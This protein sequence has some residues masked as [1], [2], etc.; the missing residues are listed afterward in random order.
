MM[1][2]EYRFEYPSV[3]ESEDRMLDDLAEIMFR[4]EV[5]DDTA[6]HVAL[7]VSEAFTNALVH[8]NCWEPGKL[9]RLRI[10]LNDAE[11]RA[12]ITDEGRDGLKRIARRRPPSVDSEGGRG[13]DL[14]SHYATD[15]SFRENADGGLTVSLRFVRD[16][17]KKD[18]VS[19]IEHRE[20]A[21]DISMREVGPVAVVN[22]SG[23]LD[24][25]S[26]TM[27]KEE[28]KK[29]FDRNITNIHLNMS[30]VDFINSSGLGALVS[31]MK[32]VRLLKGR[33]TLSNLASYVKEIFDITQL[34]HIF[35]IF[36]TEDEAMASY[37]SVASH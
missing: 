28:M 7:A 20:D 31:L 27:L 3:R 29:L 10:V 9:V 17:K 34:S 14:L 32:E 33:L 37:Q 1:A 22:L 30:A 24:L 23:R 12:D 19:R 4:H 13:I 8:A 15:V 6:H 18:A 21:M 25:N 16:Q 35:E 2:A 5:D 11:I 36:A 26:G